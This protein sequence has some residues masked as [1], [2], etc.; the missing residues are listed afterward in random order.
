MEASPRL[1]KRLLWKRMSTFD[2]RTVLG[3]LV[4]GAFNAYLAFNLY[5]RLNEDT[6]PLS[7]AAAGTQDGGVYVYSL[8]LRN[9]ETDPE[10]GIVVLIMAKS[11]GAHTGIQFAPSLSISSLPDPL[12]AQS[13][14][15]DNAGRMV[16]GF[17]SWYLSLPGLNQGESITVTITHDQQLLFIAVDVKSASGS[18]T[19]QWN[20]YESQEL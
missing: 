15:A 17:A 12:L 4:V 13:V 10:T 5:M 20:T 14:T 18:D 16:G 3:F 19:I 1:V 7:I 9:R 6:Y 8:T 11:T 2:R